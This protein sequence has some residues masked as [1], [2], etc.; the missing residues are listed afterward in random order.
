MVKV[1][2]R[3]ADFKVLERQNFRL[4]SIYTLITPRFKRALVQKREAIRQ[5]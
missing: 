5:R 3:G 4:V 2:S 1:F